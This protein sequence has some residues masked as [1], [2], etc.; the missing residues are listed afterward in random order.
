MVEH[1]AFFAKKVDLAATEN[2]KLNGF[3]GQFIGAAK[4]NQTIAIETKEF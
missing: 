3:Q 2:E 1:F 4:D